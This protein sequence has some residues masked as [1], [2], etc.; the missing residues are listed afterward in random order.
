[1]TTQHIKSGLSI[2]THF[3][4]S[5]G[6]AYCILTSLSNVAEP[7]KIAE[8][9]ELEDL[10]FNSNDY[11]LK[12]KT[13]LMVNNVTDP[14]L[15]QVSE[16]TYEVLDML[17]KN[18]VK[19]PV[20]MI[21]KLSPTHDLKRYLGK[22]NLIV[23]YTF[24][25]LEPPIEIRPMKLTIKRMNDFVSKVPFEMRYHYFRPMI[26][27]VNDKDEV[28]R[29]VIGGVHDKFRGTVA[30][31]LRVLPKS[32][33]KLAEKGRVVL[34]ER[35]Y[36]KAHKF[37][38]E[39]ITQRIWKI[40]DEIAPD[41]PLFR[42]T[43]CVIATHIGEPEALGQIFKENQCDPRCSQHEKCLAFKPKIDEKLI[44]Y[45]KSH[46]G[47][48]FSIDNDTIVF[49]GEISEELKGSIRMTSGFKVKADK[50]AYSD[51]ESEL[52]NGEQK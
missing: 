36:D 4:C 12:D 21:T 40:R 52:L 38:A 22:L 13:T 24:S 28:I 46:T 42:H 10:L 29:R 45:I 16:S 14:F 44:N 18:N 19:S 41:Y 6:C 20:I 8:V 39:G 7:K 34:I 37:L 50:I 1:M 15:P 43:S 11:Y 25:G 32:R 9:S 27:G 35:N 26:E 2:N 5:L 23:F 51:S 48:P 31:G 17:V 3:G 33:A 49:N 30:G 47:A